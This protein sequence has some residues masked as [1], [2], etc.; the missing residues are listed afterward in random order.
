MERNSLAV[1]DLSNN[2]C[3]TDRLVREQW[4]RTDHVSFVMSQMDEWK[5]ALIAPTCILNRLLLNNTKMTV[6]GES[7]NPNS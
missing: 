3:G 7:M 2:P 6:C 1:L 5:R 4:L